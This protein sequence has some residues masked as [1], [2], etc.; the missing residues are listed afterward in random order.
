MPNVTFHYEKEGWSGELALQWA[1]KNGFDEFESVFLMYSASESGLICSTSDAFVELDFLTMGRVHPAYL[2][3][4]RQE[5][6]AEV[7]HF[8]KFAEWDGFSVLVT[9]S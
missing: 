1:L 5:G 4:I 7:I 6:G 3:G 9:R 2:C 8:E